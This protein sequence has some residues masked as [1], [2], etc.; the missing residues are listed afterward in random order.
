MAEKQV[1][2]AGEPEPDSTV[3]SKAGPEA[4]SP[5]TS[6]SGDYDHTCVFCRVAAGQEPDTELLHCEVGGDRPVWV[7][8]RPPCPSLPAGPRV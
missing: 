5:A 8:P 3:A 6:E 2:L 4:A 7:G 1:D